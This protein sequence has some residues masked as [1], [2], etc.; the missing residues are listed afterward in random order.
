MREE[1]TR[2]RRATVSI[3][4]KAS[5]GFPF[6]GFKLVRV[7][8]TC[9]VEPAPVAVVARLEVLQVGVTVTSVEGRLEKT[10][11]LVLS[12]TG[13]KLALKKGRQQT[14]DYPIH[15]RVDLKRKHTGKHQVM[16][17]YLGFKLDGLWP[18]TV[19][20]R[21]NSSGDR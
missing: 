1:V 3:A 16:G 4:G 9:A 6:S 11:W 13:T 19:E 10:R 7:F 2:S 17:S 8:F 12:T 21:G 20:P 14:T 18:S 15:L 5:I